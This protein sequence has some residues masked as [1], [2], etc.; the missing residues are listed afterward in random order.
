[1]RSNVRE[2]LGAVVQQ[3]KTSASVAGDVAA[4]A[5]SI[6]QIKAANVQQADLIDGLSADLASLQPAEN[7]VSAADE[8]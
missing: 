6:G 3:A 4:V 1:M 2:I 8:A 7:G 5:A